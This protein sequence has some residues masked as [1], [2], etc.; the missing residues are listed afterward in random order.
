MSAETV[1]NLEGA[2]EA[3][4]AR[5]A[6]LTPES[7]R[8]WIRNLGGVPAF[9]VTPEEAEALARRLEARHQVTMSL[10]SALRERDY[11]PWLDTARQEIDFY[12]W[13]R[14]RKLLQQKHLPHEVIATLHE[15]TDRTLNF[16]Q[17]P[18]LKG[19]WKRRGM[20]VGHVQSG[21]TSNYTGL[22]C[23]AADAGYKLIIVIAG[24]HNNLRNQTQKRID[25]GLIGRDSARL[26]SRNDNKFIGVGRIDAQRRPVTFTNSVKDFSKQ[27]ATAVGVPLQN[28]KE[29]A[30]FVIKKNDKTLTNLVEWLKEHNARRGEQTIDEPMLLI[31]DEADN[32]SINVAYDRG[33][34]SKINKQIRELLK[35][36]DRSCHVG[37]TATPFANIFID[38]DTVHDMLGEDLFPRHFIVSLDPPSNYFGPEKVFGA[39]ADGVV[40][41]IDDA[42]TLPLSHKRD[43]VVTDLPKTLEKAIRAFVLARAVRMARGD[44]HEHM[45]ML[46]NASRFTDVQGRIRAAIVNELETV[47][48]TARLHGALPV[49]K[50]ML[51]P[52][53]ERLKSVWDEVFGEVDVE[54]ADIQRHLHKSASPVRV[55]EV[56]SRSHGTL[57]YDEYDAGLSVIAVGGYSLSRGLTLEGLMTSYFLRNSMMYDTLMQMGR[58]F[59]YRSGYE[60]V[61]RI[62][63]PEEA[64]GWYS[65]IT[66]AIEELREEL[67]VMAAAGA[68]PEQFGLKVR[69]HP[70]AL[71]VTAKNKMGS[72][73][74]IVVDI[75]LAN[76]FIETWM[77]LR[78]DRAMEANYEALQRFATRI[79][80]EVESQEMFGGGQ[81]L[82]A[83]PGNA[84]VDFLIAFKNHPDAMLTDTG[85]VVRYIQDRIPGEL[86]KWDVLVAGVK[87]DSKMRDDRT[88]W[89]TVNCQTRTKGGRSSGRTLLVSNK[90]RVASRGAERAGV[91]S[92]RALA[93]EQIFRE[94]KDVKEGDEI[95]Y[96]DRIYRMVRKRPLLIVHLLNVEEDGKGMFAN[97]VVAWSIG[98][99]DTRVPEKK[100][101]YIV[102]RQWMRENLGDE[103]TDD[104]ELTDDEA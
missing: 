97:P 63:M 89:F 13:G 10:G 70:A 69:A 102:T 62:W 55:V 54:W 72:G 45:S 85:P 24:I 2:V 77:L 25:E 57:N 67:R 58:W 99:P 5:Q 71:I 56:N 6:T 74:K 73:E 68:T 103:S 47:Q 100:V 83:I 19:P 87:D 50:A 7:I 11:R 78:E 90:Q 27:S 39:N 8:Q 42:E 82:K 9:E 34:T 12:Y 48:V 49:D 14:Y 93:A 65:H 53:M 59:G 96:P 46:V 79:R 38:P 66:D 64:E 80:D 35:L 44:G 21:K 40:Q 52:E 92:E 43:H 60:D 32:A 75:G 3:M 1:G 86:E 15:D 94:K 22:I 4:L 95:N 101:Q 81:L 17:N 37:Y 33:E 91:E 84:V 36:F 31:D 23:K 88:F 41:Y 18:S 26:F 104:D 16:L 61:C 29:P 98:F 20:V 30:V 51:D 28:L 76:Q